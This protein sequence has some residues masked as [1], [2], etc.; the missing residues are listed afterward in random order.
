MKTPSIRYVVKILY[1]TKGLQKIHFTLKHPENAIYLTG[2]AVS[3]TYGRAYGV[4]GREERIFTDTTGTLSLA[5]PEKGDVFYTESLKIETGD[6]SEFVE[7]TIAPNFFNPR[8]GFSAKR[9]EYFTTAVPITG[10]LMEGY[11]EDF[12]VP[13]RGGGFILIDGG[14]RSV[15]YYKVTLYLRYQMHEHDNGICS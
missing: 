7:E 4:I 11:Y 2:I 9:Y 5:I 10:N 8:F 15:S 14:D 3:G 13:P 6:F 1:I 12:V